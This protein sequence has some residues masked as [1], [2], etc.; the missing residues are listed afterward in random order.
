MASRVTKTRFLKA[1]QG[2]GGIL[3]MVA[4]KLSCS[5]ATVY[6]FINKNPDM[7]KAIDQEREQILDA[8]QHNVYSRIQNNDWDATRYLLNTLGK[9][10]GFTTS[11]E[12]EHKGEITNHFDGK[13][14]I[15]II[16]PHKQK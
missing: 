10:R 15:E 7:Q 6:N 4:Q 1:V 9:Q 11:M 8:A 12:L 3:T 13:L 2:T 5:R 14:E 16:E